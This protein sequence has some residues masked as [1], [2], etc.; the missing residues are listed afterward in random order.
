MAD[1]KQSMQLIVYE[2]PKEFYIPPP[3]PPA[4][5]VGYSTPNKESVLERRY[6]SVYFQAKGRRAVSDGLFCCPLEENDGVPLPKKPS[7]V[8]KFFSSDDRNRGIF[9]SYPAIMKPQKRQEKH[10]SPGNL[11][12]QEEKT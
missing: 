12:I 5:R 7:C 4:A 8:E 1:P 2:P 3:P 9:Q 11:N 10:A 6:I